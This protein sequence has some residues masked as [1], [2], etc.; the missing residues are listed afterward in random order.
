MNIAL[1]EAWALPLYLV[2]A[3]VGDIKW[4]GQ[5][6]SILTVVQQSS[7]QH[8]LWPQRACWNPDSRELSTCAT[9]GQYLTRASISSSVKWV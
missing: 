3:G 7:S 8:G 5:G 4:A 1:S 2:V 6:P 9:L